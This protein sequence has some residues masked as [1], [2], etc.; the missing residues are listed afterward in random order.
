MRLE[1]PRNPNDYPDLVDSQPVLNHPIAQLPHLVGSGNAR[2]PKKKQRP[3]I[4]H[5]RQPQVKGNLGKILLAYV[6]Q[7]FPMKTLQCQISQGVPSLSLWLTWQDFFGAHIS[8]L[9]SHIYKEV[10][11]EELSSSLPP[12]I[13]KLDPQI[14]NKYLMVWLQEFMFVVYITLHFSFLV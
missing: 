3:G 5:S 1:E 10:S 8:M 6:S 7:V 11:R 4:L 14:L 13:P 2:S 12:H 9:W